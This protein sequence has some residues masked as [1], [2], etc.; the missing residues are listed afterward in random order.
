MNKQQLINEL[1]YKQ[2]ER[3]HSIMVLQNQFADE[4][5][6]TKATR[7]ADRIN[8]LEEKIHEAKKELHSLIFVQKKPS[9]LA[10]ILKF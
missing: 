6:I 2:A 4:T 8:D 7:M 1:T 9:L 10:R 3:L 5:D